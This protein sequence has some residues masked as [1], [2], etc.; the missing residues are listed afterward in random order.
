MLGIGIDFGT[1]NSSAAIYDGGSLRYVDV[2]PVGPEREVMPTALY[3]DRSLRAEVGKNAISAY[4][5]ENEGR[6]IALERE[7]VGEIEIT[8]AGGA[9]EERY[10]GPNSQGGTITDNVQVFA[11]TD[12]AL[13]GR[14]FRGLKRWLGNSALER[15][16]VFD[17]SYRI[18]ALITPIL[19]QLQQAT[20]RCAGSGRRAINVGRP[21]RFEGRGADADDVACGRLLEACG[22]AGLRHPNLTPEPV[23]ATLSF[24]HQSD[25]DADQTILAFDFGGG[26]L[27]LSVV[28][29]LGGRFELLATTGIPIGGD[30]IDRAV[31]RDVIFPELGR[32]SLVRVPIGPDLV[33]AE[34][35]F[36][37]FAER[38]LNWPLAY[39]LNRAELREQIV[40]GIREGGDTARRLGRLYQLVTRNQSYRVF[41][42]VERAKVELSGARRAALDVPE[43]DLSVS[44][45][46]ARFEKTLEPFL[47][48]IRQCVETL[49]ARAQLGPED[50]T[51]VVRTGGSSRIPAVV[52]LLEEIFC[53]RVVEHDPFT[54]IAAVLALASFHG[55]AST[56]ERKATG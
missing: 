16:R 45:T 36:D 29:A 56:A 55:Y 33:T 4:M 10:E 31:Y 44:L 2:E 6:A 27:D 34:F 53:G 5:R 50:I 15:V 42:A 20:A 41:Q 49:L 8:V 54:S 48:E 28:R 19:Q 9:E 38:L 7:V 24:L 1:S 13:P 39:E 14:L 52:R 46:R 47:R 11:L 51:R 26:T 3:L 17:K 35:Y 12:R 32:G 21:V 25:P 22:Y 18:V 30:A 40:Q 43:L 23:A 37:P